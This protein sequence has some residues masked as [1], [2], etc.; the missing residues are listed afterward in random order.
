MNEFSPLPAI[1]AGGR[2]DIG[3]FAQHSPPGPVFYT[4]GIV[5]VRLFACDRFPQGQDESAGLPGYNAKDILESFT[6]EKLLPS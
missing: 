6:G 4:A 3:V 2:A 1:F 5:T